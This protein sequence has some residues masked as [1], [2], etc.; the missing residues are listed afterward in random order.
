MRT[1]KVGEFDPAKAYPNGKLPPRKFEAPKDGDETT[2]PNG[3]GSKLKEIVA[4]FGF[5][6]CQRC[7]RLA[8]VMDKLGPKAVRSRLDEFAGKLSENLVKIS[9]GKAKE[10]GFWSVLKAKAI[11]AIVPGATLNSLSK[12]MILRA[13]ERAESHQADIAAT[14]S[15]GI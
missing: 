8:A 1:W 15:P 3:V 6:P 4:L 7:V 13:C 12:Q 11:V 5:K 2:N 9:K 14:Q 10:L